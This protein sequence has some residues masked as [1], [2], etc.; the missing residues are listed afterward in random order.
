MQ[1][2][3]FT[4]LTNA[5]SRKPENHAAA[6]SLHVAWYNLCRVHESLS[7]TLAMALGVSNHIWS[8]GEL[9]ECRTDS[10]EAS[11]DHPGPASANAPEPARVPA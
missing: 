5:F 11:A 6:I 2:R 8:I 1:I 10:V 9:V 4:R 3:R 7:T